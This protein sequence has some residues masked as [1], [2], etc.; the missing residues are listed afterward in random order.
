MDGETGEFRTA[1][2][3]PIA[4]MR[5]WV[6]SMVSRCSARWLIS[7]PSCMA[8]RWAPMRCWSARLA[9]R[10]DH[11][12]G[13]SRCAGN[14]PPRPPKT[15]GL[16]GDFTPVIPRSLRREVKERVLSDGSIRDA[17]TRPRCVRSAKPCW[18]M[19][20]RPWRLSSSTPMPMPR[21][22]RRA[23]CACGLLPPDRLA[24]SHEILPEIREFE[25]TS[26]TRSMPVCSRG[27][28]L[29][30]EARGGACSEAFAG[31]FHIVQSNGGVMSTTTA[32]RFPVRTALS[33]RQRV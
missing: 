21:T 31:R 14:A 5:P 1:K 30:R 29:S 23:C 32:R 19:V 8:P 20:P 24:A 7:A 26:T 10:A 22:R 12:R 33:A 15:W 4:A 27:R 6:S 18:P 2:V 3:R 16:T 9:G 17:V 13:L 11:H 25:R 28:Q